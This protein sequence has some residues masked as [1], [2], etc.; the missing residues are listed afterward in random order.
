MPHRN[1]H[2]QHGQHLLGRLRRLSC[3][4]V[5]AQIPSERR[6]RLLILSYGHVL[7]CCRSYRH[8]NMPA[9]RRRHCIHCGW[10]NL[11]CDLHRLCCRVLLCGWLLAV[12]P[13]PWRHIRG[14]CR[15]CCLHALCGGTLL[16]CHRFNIGL[17]LRHVC[18]WNAF[19]RRRRNLHQ[20]SARISCFSNGINLVERLHNLPRWDLFLPEN[21]RLA[22]LCELPS[23]FVFG[24]RWSQLVFIMLGL[25]C[26]HRSKCGVSSLH[27]LYRGI[28]FPPSFPK[29][30]I[31]RTIAIRC[32]CLLL[33]PTRD[34]Q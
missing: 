7:H 4:N 8:D 22:V 28:F 30:V 20:V 31:K 27:G 9:V 5:G 1:V 33:V 11:I 13:V 19:S 3:W 26:R 17:F 24:R 34:I 6:R 12:H 29:S 25:P 18:S 15:N 14:G 16:F 23:R 21:R 10:G 2:G 32:C